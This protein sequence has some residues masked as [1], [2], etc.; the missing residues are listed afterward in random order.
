MNTKQK[1]NQALIELASA[2]REAVELAGEFGAP[3]GVLFSAMNA[4]GMTLDQYEGFMA[5]MVAGGVLRKEGH[6]YF[7]NNVNH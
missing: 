1:Y 2:V 4:H 5:G 6:L 3:S 7:I